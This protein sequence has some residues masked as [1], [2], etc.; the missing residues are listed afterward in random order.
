MSYLLELLG[1]GLETSLMSLVLPVCRPLSAQEVEM[2]DVAIRDD[3]GHIA[4]KL[5]LAIHYSQSGS[6]QK[7]EGIFDAILK[8]NPRHADARLARAA[9][10]ASAGSLDKAIEHFQE[11][12]DYFEDDSRVLFGLGHCHERKG[13]QEKAL[14]FYQQ[15]AS[16]KPYLRQARERIAAIYLYRGEYHKT[17]EQCFVVAE[18]S[19]TAVPCVEIPDSVRA[20][21]AGKNYPINR[22]SLRMIQ[23]PQ[24][25]RGEIIK[26]AYRQSY[27]TEFTDDASVVEKSG[28]TINL[29]EGNRE[30]MKITTPEDM[31]LAR[32]YYTALSK[33]NSPG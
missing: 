23:T 11:T 13:E 18:R 15:A 8:D 27:L 32:A 25:F 1:K 31:D 28:F 6:E 30:N 4:N 5:R 29:V 20:V 24:V 9:M 21:E 26:K 14:H 7:A 33:Q 12:L 17:V 2:L 16:C 22:S 3:P 19:G 10:Y